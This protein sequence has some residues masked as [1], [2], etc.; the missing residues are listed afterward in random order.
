MHQLDKE[1]IIV[2]SRI[3]GDFERALAL[4][5]PIGEPTSVSHAPANDSPHR[6]EM[7]RSRFAELT[8]LVALTASTTDFN[9]AIREPIRQRWMYGI[10]GADYSGQ[11]KR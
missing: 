11:S 6:I 10:D 8:A 4:F 5:G 3:A 1:D 9:S 7:R 2:R